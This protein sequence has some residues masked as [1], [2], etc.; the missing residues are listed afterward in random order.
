MVT[1]KFDN[2]SMRKMQRKM[3]KLARFGLVNKKELRKANRQIAKI[4]VKTARRNIQ[5]MNREYT[6]VRGNKIQRGTLRRSMGVW[7]PKGGSNT[8]MAGPRASTLKRVAAYS[9]KDGFF[10]HFVESGIARKKKYQGRNVGVFKRS[11]QSAQPQMART[12]VNEYR[13]KFK[14]YVRSL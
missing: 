9:N 7:R 8:M 4:Y 13:S 2:T 12:Q 14:K 6:T 11:M 10:A 1:V 3:D 5:P